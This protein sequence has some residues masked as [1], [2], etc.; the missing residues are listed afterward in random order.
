MPVY[1]KKQWLVTTHS[2]YESSY[3]G[4]RRK[5][6]LAGGFPIQPI[7]PSPGGAKLVEN[8]DVNNSHHATHGIIA[9]TKYQIPC[10]LEVH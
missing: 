1:V 2:A 10:E 6:R 3:Q 8:A 7:K 5:E 4:T 9:K